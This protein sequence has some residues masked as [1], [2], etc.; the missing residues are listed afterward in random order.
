MMRLVLDTNV[1]IASQQSPNE[2]SPNREL[3]TRWVAGEFVWLYSQ[4][5]LREYTRKLL[6]KGIAE[7]K[8]RALLSRLMIAGESVYIAF[9]HERNYP[10]DPDDIAFLLCAINGKADYLVTYDRHLTK[11]NNQFDFEICGPKPVNNHLN[12]LHG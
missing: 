4:D 6:E 2:Q 1:V 7:E 5:T 10:E 8:I 11:L 12:T 3:L 9:F